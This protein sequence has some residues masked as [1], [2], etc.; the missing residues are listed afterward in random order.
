MRHLALLAVAAGM[1][2]I[3][4][5][6]FTMG[7]GDEA[8]ER[9][10]RRVFVSAFEIDRDEVTRADYLRCVAAG[11]CAAPDAP[12]PPDAPPDAPITGVSWRDAD[13]YCRFL[14]KR[15]PSEAEWEKA[16]RGS[17]GRVYP[18][19]NAPDCAQANF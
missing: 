7:G 11:A 17:D 9:P 14:G 13:H 6:A 15:L 19:G 2:R 18:W 12:D 3:P 4:A 16:A 10:A 5:G 1:V 8:D